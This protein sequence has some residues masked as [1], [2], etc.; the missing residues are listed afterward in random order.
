MYIC[1]YICIYICM[2]T[3]V[4]IFIHMY[5]YKFIYVHIHVHATPYIQAVW[6]QHVKH[7]LGNHDR[8]AAV[9]R[10]ARDMYYIW[11]VL[12]IQHIYIHIYI[13]ILYVNI[14]M[15]IPT[16]I[17]IYICRLRESCVCPITQEIMT[18][19][20]LASDGHVYERGAILRCI[21][22]SLH[23]WSNVQSIRYQWSNLNDHKRLNLNDQN[24]W[25]SMIKYQWSNI[26]VDLRQ[27]NI[28]IYIY[29]YMY[30]YIHIHMIQSMWTC[31]CNV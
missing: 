25:I 7:R 1:M 15:Y 26:N 21:Q 19:P 27:Y 23:S 22:A 17:Y 30:I 16:Y 9:I 11:Y 28:Y 31:F 3:Y 24:D 6:E 2:Y 4:Y 13:Y 18:D 12:Y 14:Y 20:V 5:M 8:S 29:T 10:L